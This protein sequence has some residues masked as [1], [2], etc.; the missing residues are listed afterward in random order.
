MGV[1]DGTHFIVSC[2]KTH[3]AREVHLASLRSEVLNVLDLDINTLLSIELA[4]LII[5]PSKFT[6]EIGL[7]HKRSLLTTLNPVF[8]T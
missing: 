7:E 5:D 2:P 8:V 3:I 1:E 4:T 6:H